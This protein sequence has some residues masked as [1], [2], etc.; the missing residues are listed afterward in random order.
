MS[1]PAPIQI[2]EFTDP[3]CPVAFSAEPVRR[4]LQWVFGHHVAWRQ[5]MVVISDGLGPG[6]GPSRERVAASRRRLHETWGM[7]VDPD[8]F[9]STTAGVDAAR[10]VVAARLRDPVH[11]GAALRALRVHAMAGGELDRG[12]VERVAID[13][14]VSAGAIAA[15]DA[16]DVA[17]QLADD[18][19]VARA[20][21]PA[22]LALSHRLG[23]GGARYST[24]S[25]R[26]HA[27][28]ARF[29]LVGIHPFE[30]HDAVLANLAPQIERRPVPESVT[31]VLAWAGEPL[32]TAEVAAVMAA[33]PRHVRA[34][35]DEV[36]AFRPS[37]LDG[38]WSSR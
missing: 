22:A 1:E 26:F 29:E 3:A 8:A 18:M 27:G 32:A 2:T 20:P 38:Y 34:E 7:P 9:A 28:A 25:Y 4:R 19:A 36:A 33:D 35:L 16:Q 17:A 14:G 11:A 12:S 6:N 24:P 30:A 10:V 13:A 21:S 15:M 31:D 37:G 23:G 5:V